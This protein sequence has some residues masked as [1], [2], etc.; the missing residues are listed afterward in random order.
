[1]GINELKTTQRYLQ[2]LSGVIFC[3][4]KKEN[5]K[6]RMDNEI[7]SEI[8]DDYVIG[9]LYLLL[10]TINQEIKCKENVYE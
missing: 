10:K 3:V 1:M 4:G 6:M 5:W 2:M 7:L 8:C 9:E